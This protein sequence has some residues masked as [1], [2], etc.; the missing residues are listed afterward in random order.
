MTSPVAQ[1]R[2]GALDIAPVLFAATPIGF[3][4]GSLAVGKGL[5]PVEAAL[6]SLTVFAGAAQ[7]VA[8]EVWQSPV[9]WVVAGATALIVNLRHVLMGASLSR[10]LGGIERRWHSLVAFLLVD[11]SWA[12]A[13]RRALEK[14]LTLAYYLGLG[15]PMAL[16]WTLSSAGGAILGRFIGDPTTFGLDFAFSALFIGILGGF[17]KGAPTA[18]VL[19]TSAAAAAAAKL[20]VPGAWY[21]VI[22]GIAGVLAAAALYRE[23]EA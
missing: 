23:T 15:L 1:F 7:F 4:W 14:P 20:Y 8:I 2:S 22:G 21:I 5:S 18:A 17:W 6:M 19:A 11:E 3:L 10:H 16:C 9:S 13:E 12:F